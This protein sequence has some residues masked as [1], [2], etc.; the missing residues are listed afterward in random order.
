MTF[1]RA[2]LLTVA[3]LLAACATTSEF[4]R[5]VA[6]IPAS[7]PKNWPTS[8]DPDA[9]RDAAK[10][11]WRVFF[12]DPQLQALIE[13]ALNN[14]RDLRIAAA[15]VVEA[16]AQYGVVRADQLPTIS[17][18]GMGNS[19]RT[20]ADL[21]GTGAAVDSNRFDASLS[22]VS[23]EIDFWGRLAG[24][25]EAARRSYLA[26]EEAQRAVHLSLVADVASAYFSLV[27]I[28]ELTEQTRATLELRRQSL[29]LITRGK[30]IGAT[31]DYVVQQASGIFD[32]TLANL[33]AIEH[34]GVVARNRLDYL[35]GKVPANLPTGKSLDDQG[36]D[37]QLSPGL[38]SEVL[39]L[40]PDVVAAEQRLMAT[41]ANVGAARAA[42]L[43]KIMLTA[44]L[45]LASQGLAGLFSS[46]AWAFQP[47]ISLPIFDGGR[48]AANVDIAKARE[49]IAVAEYE[50]TIQLAFR[51]VADLLS[52]RES[53]TRQLR[54][55][56]ANASA[57]ER[58]LLI[59]QARFNGGTVG[60]LEVL[61]AQRDIVSAQQNITQVRRSQLES[62]AQ[63]YKALGGGAAV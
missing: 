1:S 50:K 51:E 46:G 18:L 5:P 31:D 7:W 25:S 17:A 56:T 48:T 2:L 13:I 8:S 27:Q 41:H 40:R 59:A 58:R 57:Q 36:L 55:S 26:T 38:P 53:L 11:H 45:G 52:A 39:L 14:N 33:A 10:T 9:V 54:A 61:E 23:F 34:Q 43:P 60:Y 15:R 42:F 37:A 49:V 29:A 35:V 21:S 30:D 47:I 63:L 62:A 20:P 44:S 19:T 22:T 6:P 3:A 12:S 16:R 24:L 32:A 28:K 4:Q